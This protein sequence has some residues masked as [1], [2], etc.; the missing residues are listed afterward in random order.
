MSSS[1]G[2]HVLGVHLS[3]ALVEKTLQN[4]DLRLYV[5]TVGF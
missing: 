4:A 5:M 1:V 3:G 2:I